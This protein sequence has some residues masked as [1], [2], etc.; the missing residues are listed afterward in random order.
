MRVL[1]TYNIKGGVGKTSTAVNLAYLSARDGARTLLWDLDPQGAA[2]FI[3]RI[4]PRVKGG[5]KGLVR[6]RS[7]LD[8]AIKGTDFDDLDLLPADFSYRNLDLLLDARKKPIAVLRQLLRPLSDD[9]DTVVLDCPPGISLVSESVM[10]AA[11]TLLI[12]LIPATLSLRTFDQ[13]TDFVTRIEARRPA[14]AGFFSMVDRRK[15]LHRDVVAALT[16]ERGDLLRTT[17]PAA[18]VIEQMAERRAPVPVFA[19]HSAAAAAYES[20]WAEIR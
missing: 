12:P 5:G 10:Y 17:I 16:A 18:S 4:K 19:P 13:L 20:L 2:S 9:Y 15:R 8:D 6:R 7:S 11:D 1:A 14:L 3:F